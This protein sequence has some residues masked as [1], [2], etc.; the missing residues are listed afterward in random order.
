LHRVNPQTTDAVKA[1]G[2][3]IL[4]AVTWRARS[5][6]WLATHRALLCR[7]LM[8]LYYRIAR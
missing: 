3:P 1:D 4:W 7:A 2:H 5:A 8:Q 6:L